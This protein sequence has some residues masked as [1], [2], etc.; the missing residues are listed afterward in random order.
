[1][2][3]DSGSKGALLP[4]PYLDF[5]KS[6]ALRCSLVF[7]FLNFQTVS[8]SGQSRP[9]WPCPVQ[10]PPLSQA[11]SLPSPQ[12]SAWGCK[13]LLFFYWFSLPFFVLLITEE[14]WR[15]GDKN[16]LYSFA[17]NQTSPWLSCLFARW[18]YYLK[19]NLTV[20]TAEV[21]NHCHSGIRPPNPLSAISGL[22]STECSE[23]ETHV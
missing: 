22:H 20:L 9:T 14:F 21:N 1:M 17:W 10:K 19:Q 12:I 16:L 18:W 13:C 11:L 15:E 5:N 6:L 23:K 4:T 7:N 2:F 3:W 8:A